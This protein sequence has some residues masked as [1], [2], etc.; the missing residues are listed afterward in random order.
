MWKSGFEEATCIDS[1]FFFKLLVL[2]TNPV[3]EAF[4]FE[5]SNDRCPILHFP[6]FQS[7]ADRVTSLPLISSAYDMVSSAYASTKESH[8][9]VKSVCDVAEK[10][11]KTMAAVAVS[12]AQPILDKLE[13]QSE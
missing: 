2:K 12:G 6:L 3:R 5:V 10:G 8:P 9:Y 11:V 13:P 7:A 1:V 4:L